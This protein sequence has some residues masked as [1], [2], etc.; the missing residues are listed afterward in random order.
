M[1]LEEIEENR[2]CR[3]SD[4]MRFREVG[5]PRKV[6]QVRLYQD[7]P[8]GKLFW[9]TGWTDREAAPTT[10]AF[11]QPVEDSG[12]GMVYLLYGGNC[13]VRFKPADREAPWDLNDPSQW[14]EPFLLLGDSQDLILEKP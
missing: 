9:V 5:P 12:S 6:L 4:M 14:G 1:I 2:N 3:P 7:D 13:G 11:V 8:N 10:A